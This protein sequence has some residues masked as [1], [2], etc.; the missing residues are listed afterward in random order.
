MA[1]VD[2]HRALWALGWLAWAS[3]PVVFVMLMRALRREIPSGWMRAAML[4]ALAALV[5]DLACDAVWILVVPEQYAR[6]VEV[7]RWAT[8]GGTI[9]ANPAY[10]VAV[11]FASMAFEDR[12][13]RIAGIAT[14]GAALL[15]GAAGATGNPDALAVTTVLTMGTYF[16]W[17]A[18]VV[19]GGRESRRP[20]AAG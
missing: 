10:G 16:A 8:L 11:A 20:R 12:R 14:L 13:V 1:F 9:V 19:R 3:C 7:E 6:L 2:T 4:A 15:L 5:L 18:A 17:L